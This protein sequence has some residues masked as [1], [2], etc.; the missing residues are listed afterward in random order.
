MES[1]YAPPVVV[2]HS[3]LMAQCR[4]REPQHAAI[5]AF[6]YERIPNGVIP[7]TIAKR[8]VHPH[9]AESFAHW[10]SDTP[11]ENDPRW[12]EVNAYTSVLFD[13]EWTTLGNLAG[14]ERQTLAF[15]AYGVLGGG[16]PL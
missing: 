6:C 9:C 12:L 2:S 15:N 4:R 1:I 5:C 10:I 16:L 14:N 7:V 8:S 13:D 3:S 11:A